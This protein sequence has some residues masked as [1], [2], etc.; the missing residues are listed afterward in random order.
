MLLLGYLPPNP[1]ELLMHSRFQSLIQSLHQSFDMVIIDAPPILAVSDAAI[2]GRFTTA[3]L[4]VVRAGM[5]P[6]NEI[7]QAVRRLAQAGVAVKGFVFNDLSEKYQKYRH[8]YQGYVY[9]Y[10]YDKK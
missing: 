7:E 4:M 2:V 10:K 1:S 9:R 8:G 3:T 5:H 6:L